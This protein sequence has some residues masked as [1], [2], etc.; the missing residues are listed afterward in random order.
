[1]SNVGR[2]FV[3]KLAVKLK[4]DEILGVDDFEV[5]ACYQDLWKTESEKHNT[6]RQ[7]IIHGSDCTE[8]CMKL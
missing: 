3:K 4:G 5:F 7:G 8:N 1:M 2:A 6:V